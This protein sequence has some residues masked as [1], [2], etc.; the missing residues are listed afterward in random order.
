MISIGTFTK[1]GKEFHGVLETLSVLKEVMFIPKNPAMKDAPDYSVHYAERPDVIG[2]G[3][4]K[5][6]DDRKD[7]I[8]VAIN[9]PSFPA[10]INCRLVKTGGGYSL[11][12]DE[13]RPITDDI[14]LSAMLD[15][16]YD[17]EM[18]IQEMLQDYAKQPEDDSS[19]HKTLKVIR[20]AIEKAEEV[21]PTLFS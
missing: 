10:P 13:R 5:H 3:R 2:F 17:A 4:K 18:E 6:G 16:L 8:H 19:A 12:W 15:A 9:D 21:A 20:A 7:Y 11:L 1:R 14:V